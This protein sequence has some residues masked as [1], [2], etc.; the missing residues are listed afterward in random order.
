MVHLPVGSRCGELG[1][2]QADIKGGGVSR[3]TGR[4]IKEREL[5]AVEEMGDIRKGV[6]VVS[7]EP[8]I[9][10]VEISGYQGREV[11]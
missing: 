4:V 3:R 5:S 1:G 10:S 9:S 7:T 11:G 2:A 8:A 6:S